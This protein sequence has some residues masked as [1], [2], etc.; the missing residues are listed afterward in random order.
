M[1]RRCSFFSLIQIINITRPREWF[2]AA[3]AADK[4][5]IPGQQSGS[6][7]PRPQRADPT[8]LSL[9]RRS[10]SRHPGLQRARELGELLL[11]VGGDDLR[12]E[13]RVAVE[14]MVLV[15]WETVSTKNTGDGRYASQRGGGGG[16]RTYLRP[17]RFLYRFLQTSQE[18]GF[19]FSMPIVPGY[20]AQVSGSTI[21]KVPSSFS[22][23]C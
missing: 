22:C 8:A 7:W 5:P 19:S 14:G 1:V 3:S 6:V 4:P 17:L 23:S 15:L 2:G 13:I 20:G 16:V 18:Y 10:S 21:E 11:D 12:R 9:P